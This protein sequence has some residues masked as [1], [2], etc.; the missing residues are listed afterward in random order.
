M[1]RLGALVTLVALLGGG[2]RETAPP[3]DAAT[4][5][6]GAAAAEWTAYGGDAL[7][8]RFSPLADITR[9]N[10]TS[11]AVAWTFRTGETPKAEPT[12]RPTAFEATPILVDG[13]LYFST[14]LGK[15]F[16]LDPETGVQRWRFDADVN[17]Q[18]P[19]GDFTNRGVSTWLDPAAAEGAPCR[20]RIFLAAVDARL[21]ALDAR[22]GDPCADF[23][24]R[25]TVDLRT[26]LRNPP[27]SDGEYAMTSPPAIVNGVVVIGSSVADNGRTDL[28][29]GEI[30]GFDAR[31]G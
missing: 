25:G 31:T 9:D 24:E 14:P 8:A 2:A 23:G 1:R 17:P 30:R 3:A 26:G 4:P 19:F 7:G 27:Q 29:S 18:T 20:R 15:V 11:L 28:A 6:P 16:A 22:T 12:R 13:T 5:R 10:V 21:I